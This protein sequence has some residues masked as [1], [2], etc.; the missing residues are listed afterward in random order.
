MGKLTDSRDKILI[1]HLITKAHIKVC[2]QPNSIDRYFTNVGCSIY[3]TVEDGYLI[4]P[5]N[6][7][8]CYY[9]FVYDAGDNNVV[10]LIQTTA[11]SADTP[12]D[13]ITD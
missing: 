7:S 13:Y 9:L 5:Q 2:S 4:F 1:N 6:L 8:S 11:Y 10:S 3:A 12:E